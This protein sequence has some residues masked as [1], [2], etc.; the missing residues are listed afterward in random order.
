MSTT[1]TVNINHSRSSIDILLKCIKT[2]IVYSYK[3]IRYCIH[4]VLILLDRIIAFSL[5]NTL[6]FIGN[7]LYLLE[8]YMHWY[9]K[10]SKYIEDDRFDP[11]ISHEQVIM[12]WMGLKNVSKVTEREVVREL[13]VSQWYARKIKHVA[14][15]YMDYFHEY[16]EIW[17]GYKSDSEKRD[18]RSV[19]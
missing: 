18:K 9:L 15:N 17:K 11:G 14:K 3:I 13:W 16:A 1:A 4:S 8:T 12:L 7:V 19:I 10:K 6:K 2:I 5:Y